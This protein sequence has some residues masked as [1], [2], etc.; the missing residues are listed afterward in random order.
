VPLGSLVIATTNPGKVREIRRTL[1]GLPVRLLTLADFPAVQEPEEAG[2][3]F[4]DNAHNKAVYYCSRIGTP[5]V[6]DDSGLAIDALGGRPG[7]ASARYPG[8]TYAEKFVN[9]YRELAP[10]PRP[11]IAR[12]VCSV[13][14][15][16]PERG[17]GSGSRPAECRL[18][19]SCE[20][21]VEWEI[22][23]N[24][25]GAN[26]FGYDPIFYYRPYGRTLGQVSEAEKL[27]ISHRGLA[28]RQL[29][30]WLSATER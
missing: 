10:H 19:F 5:A 21:A 6:A 24:P 9:L 12:F 1:E 16:E 3:T 7:V 8:D 17:A 23:P 15:C 26:G 18:A 13:A 25:R 22:E 20:A 2:A 27:E 14:L 29:R 4:A 11:W 30:A 28:F